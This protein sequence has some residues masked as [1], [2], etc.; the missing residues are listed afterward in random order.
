MVEIRRELQHQPGVK[1]DDIFFA[2]FKRKRTIIVWAVLGI[3]AAAAYYFFFPPVYE[4]QAKLLVRYVLERSAVD[5]MDGTKPMFQSSNDPDRVIG[6][7]IEI[8]TSWDLAMQ[9]AQAIGP[10]R[11]LAPAPIPDPVKRVVEAVGLKQLPSASGASAS[12]TDAARSIILG[13]KVLS[14]K[15]S[16]IIFVSYK[17]RSPELAT[18]VLQELLS[19]YF[20]KH[21]E[22]H[23][24]AGAFDFVSQQTDQVRTR[25]SQTE[26]ALKSLRDKTGIASLK[27]GSAALTTEA[28][29]TREQLDAAEAELAEHQLLANRRTE[30][31]SKGWKA[32]SQTSDK[33]PLTEKSRVAGMEAKVALLKSRLDDIQQRTKQLSELTPQMEELER[34]RELDEANYKYFAE[35]LEKARIDEAL[36]PSKMPNI[37]AV[38]RPSPPVIVT[39]TRFKKTLALA[40][41]GLALGLALALL[42]GLFLNQ[43][44]GR[45]LELETRLQIPLM[46]SI[47]YT[48]SR[49][50]HLRLPPNGSPTKSLTLSTRSRHAE[51]P[52]WE[53]GHFIRP[54]CDALRDRLG[55]YFELNNLTH[56]P[57]LVGVTGFSEAA[58]TSTL[59]A[60]LA[61]SLSETND[62][63]VLLVDIN[64]GPEQVHPFFKGKP[65][66]S[67][68][69]ALK[70]QTEIASASENLYLA[71]VGSSTTGGLA[72]VGLKK[73]FDMMP[74][75]KASDFDYIIFDMPPL[76]QTSPT[77]GMAAFMD[78]L[79][80][81]VEAEKNNREVIKRGY[82]KLVTERDNVA[83]VVNKARCYVPKL[84]NGES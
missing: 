4:S 16:N 7:E 17:N 24:S 45:P 22:V 32:N 76:D 51:L 42:R 54:Y 73:F 27:E 20:V 64:L 2:L 15:G 59:A 72:Q 66:Y 61:A 38:Q 75:M 35:S 83:V 55:F 58:G 14:N 81:V 82:R 48:N 68:T 25:L 21:L 47:P 29:K 8:L 36:D 40:G 26:N 52:P 50:G 44:V 34:K 63:K 67:L 6:A 13:L 5:S 84:L 1:L 19:R 71:T 28:A 10:K 74:N 77:W 46:L 23:R 37:S 79:L 70:P 53:T 56:K 39:T 65:A 80:L 30:S 57:K 78:K 9:V 18:L 62:G 41:G 43:T 12:E 49:N 3:I 60:G 33:S 69:A 31:G 11:L